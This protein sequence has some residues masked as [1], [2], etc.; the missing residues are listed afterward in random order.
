[1][2]YIKSIE[3]L[4]KVYAKGNNYIIK[5]P[6]PAVN[7]K[8]LL[9]H[10]DKFSN[11]TSA[12]ILSLAHHSGYLLIDNGDKFLSFS[13]Y[14]YYVKDKNYDANDK[15]LSGVYAIEYLINKISDEKTREDLKNIIVNEI[16]ITPECEVIYYQ[17]ILSRSLRIQ[18]LI[19]LNCPQL[20]IKNGFL[21][22]QEVVGELFGYSNG[23]A[24]DNEKN[25]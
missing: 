13:E 24:I 19:E 15:K 17:R 1:M 4:E 20:I 25:C 8:L 21:L 5:L 3:Q 7:T 14:L 10:L 11:Y 6:V 9:E 23:V 18:K 2:N 22:L 12:E 16:C